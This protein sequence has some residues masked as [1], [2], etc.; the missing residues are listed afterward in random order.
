MRRQKRVPVQ[1]LV[2]KHVGSILKA[3]AQ[4][5]GVGVSALVRKYLEE[6][7]MHLEPRYTPVCGC[8]NTAIMHGH[9]DECPLNRQLSIPDLTDVAV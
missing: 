4:R 9:T 1:C 6:I 3:E 2:S 8:Q 7:A 5:Q